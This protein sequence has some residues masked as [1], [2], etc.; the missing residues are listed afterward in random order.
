MKNYLQPQ[1]LL[2]ALTAGFI[3]AL[4]EVILS[5]SFAALIF[6]GELSPFVSRG[7]GLLL[8]GAVVGGAVVAL[9]SSLPGVVGGNQDAPAAIMAV[10][11]A[12][13]V[14]AIPPDATAQDSFVTV[15][16]A[17]ALTTLLTALFFLLLGY[18]RSGG[19][20]RFMPFPVIGGFL[21]G[22]GWLLLAGSLSFMSG[23]PFDLSELADYFQPDILL[24]W[25]PGLLFALIALVAANRINHYLVLP[26]LIVGGALVF[27]LFMALSGLSVAEAQADGLLLGPFPSGSVWQPLTI[28]E[29]AAANWSAVFS[30]IADI[31][32]ILILSTIAL[33]L[34]AGGLELAVKRDINL[35]RELR[36]AGLAN[37]LIAPLGGL[38]GYQQLSLSALN[39]NMRADNR[40]TGLMA[41]GFGLMVLL[42]GAGMLALLP[43]ALLG[44]LLLFLGLSFLVEWLYHAWFKLSPL[45]YAILVLILAVIATVG[46]LEGV[47]V[48]LLAAVLLF[49]ISY[50]RT[51]VIRQSLSGANVRSRVT[52]PAAQQRL[53]RQAGQELYVL[54]LQGFIFFGTAD[55]LTTT[56][57][58]RLWNGAL[59]KPRI[60]ILDFRRVTGVDSSALLSFRRLLQL[61]K[62]EQATLIFTEVKPRTR[63]QLEQGDLPEQPPLLYYFPDLD[64]GLEWSENNILAAHG[65]SLSEPVDLLAQLAQIVPDITLLEALLARFDYLEVPVGEYLMREGERPETLYL[66]ADGRA[67][68]QLERQGEAPVRLETMQ[69]GRVVGE[70]GF[71]LG[72][73]RTACVI[74]DTPSHIYRLTRS[75]L[76]QMEAEAPALASA[77]HR[78]MVHLL[79]DRVTHLVSAVDALQN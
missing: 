33:L 49:V 73:A 76:A 51:D 43:I 20:A 55:R 59:P 13:I 44:G 53:L 19:L 46:F 14:V 34:N 5:V 61:V 32:T 41:A 29:L 68:A 35:N 21:A 38:A 17:I 3:I 74:V 71:Y 24:R 54:R 66:L 77:L 12:A 42:F 26:G 64:H 37:L 25:L 7:V 40:L 79:A 18:L 36:A 28:G 48:G 4:L 27:Y 22:T 67:T 39:F 8:M 2:P 69:S 50:S 63:R 78:I 31:A 6:T 45:E 65:V 52:R 60:I 30:R 23:I 58:E 70:L 62:A 1:Q 72:Q 10:V 11:A 56:V 75:Q 16:A 9:F 57:R 15:I 47:G